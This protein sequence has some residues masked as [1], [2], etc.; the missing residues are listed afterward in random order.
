M[1]VMLNGRMYLCYKVAVHDPVTNLVMITNMRL[2]QCET[3]TEHI[4]VVY[5]FH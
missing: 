1:D 4:L 5:K 2:L 3:H